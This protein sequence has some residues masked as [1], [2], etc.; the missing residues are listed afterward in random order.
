MGSLDNNNLEFPTH[1]SR[2]NIDLIPYYWC[3]R[4]NIEIRP[5]YRYKNGEHQ[6]QIT[7][8]IGNKTNIDPKIYEKKDI[9]DKIY[10][11]SNYYY[12]KYS[13]STIEEDEKKLRP[14]WGGIYD[15]EKEQKI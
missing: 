7:I 2:K 14:I 5:Q 9:M 15:N 12:K 11:Y 6:W 4:N 10:E 3:D 8:T 13:N 1:T